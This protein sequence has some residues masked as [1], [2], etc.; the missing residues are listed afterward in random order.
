MSDNGQ[1][2]APTPSDRPWKAHQH[3]PGCWSVARDPLPGLGIIEYM[4]GTTMPHHEAKRRAAAANGVST[5]SSGLASFR[6]AQELA[7]RF[8]ETHWRLAP[9]FGYSDANTRLDLQ[10]KYG[11]LM[12]A[13]CQE[14][15]AGGQRE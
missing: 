4:P 7:Q 13:V 1:A 10:S 5:P 9:Q 2:A 15:L 8:Y 12:V 3:S 14:L 11:R 6:D